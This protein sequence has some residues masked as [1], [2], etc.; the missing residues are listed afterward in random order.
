MRLSALE[1]P[2]V[3]DL[4]PLGLCNKLPDINKSACG[5]AICNII[6]MCNSSVLAASTVMRSRDYDLARQ[7]GNLSLESKCFQFAS[8]IM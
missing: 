1:P 8:P 2:Q 5:A 4:Y 6:N 7:D 3:N